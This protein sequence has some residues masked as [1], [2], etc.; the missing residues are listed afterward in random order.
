MIEKD[1]ET[2]IVVMRPL[3]SNMMELLTTC[4]RKR[5]I[6]GPPGCGKSTSLYQI[7]QYC[8]LADCIVLMFERNSQ[9]AND[10]CEKILN[11]VLDV[12]RL[13]FEKAKVLLIKTY[14]GK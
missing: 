10:A 3:F 14:K 7:A 4:S 5:I 8:K 6:R 9:E 12:N 13:I 2:I 1:E 11:Y